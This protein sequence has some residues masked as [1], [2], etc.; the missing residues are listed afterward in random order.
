MFLDLPDDDGSTVKTLAIKTIYADRIRQKTK[1]WELRT[2]SPNVKPGGWLALYESSPTKAIQTVVQIGRT[3]KLDP[4]DAWFFY[5]DQFGIDFDDYFLY[6]R[7]RTFAFGMEIV[8]VRSF[9]PVPLHILR[10]ECNF[11]VPQMCMTLRSIHQ[12]IYNSIYNQ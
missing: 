5:S 11:S 9:D 4:D 6:Y 3:F 2:Y 8:D 1:T 12:S 7:K 10:E